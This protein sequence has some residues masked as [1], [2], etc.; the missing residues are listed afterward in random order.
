MT[1]LGSETEET[2]VADNLIDS[3][4]SSSASD[5]DLD[6]VIEGHT[7]ADGVTTFVVQTATLDASDGTTA[8]ALDTPLFRVTRIYNA[9]TT[10]KLVGNIY[11]YEDDTGRTDAKTHI[12]IP[13]GEQKSQK[14][15][16]T[17]SSSDYWIVTNF[18][19]SVLTTATKYAQ[20]R[21]E[22]K[23]TGSSVW[24]P[25]TQNI[26]CTDTTGTIE[27]LKEPYIIVPKN[28]DVRLAVKTNTSG[29]AVAGGFS[30]YLAS[31]L[32]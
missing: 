26:S 22:V 9:D 27:L 32:S 1:A 21:I 8:V 10:T 19:L 30:G 3:I 13:A 25:I 24:L 18:S 14:A 28:Y 11:V 15:A 29:V 20:A 4:V 17:I 2:F 7:V 31:V 6:I 5:V 23:P 12:S 16:T